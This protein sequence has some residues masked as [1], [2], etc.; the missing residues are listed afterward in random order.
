MGLF[1]IAKGD[2]KSIVLVLLN[3]ID[4]DKFDIE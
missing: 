4:F 2:P 1:P 3:I